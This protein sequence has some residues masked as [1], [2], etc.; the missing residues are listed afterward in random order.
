MI[1][2]LSE[3]VS[4]SSSQPHSLSSDTVLNWKPLASRRGFGSASLTKFIPFL[5]SEMFKMEI[6]VS[7]MAVCI[8]LYS[9]LLVFITITL[10]N[11]CSYLLFYSLIYS[12]NNG[13]YCATLSGD[14][15]LNMTWYWSHGSQ[16]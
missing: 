15:I 5:E 14:G 9:F 4:F 3:T 7:R 12:V 6:I 16:I 1:Q 2:S 11:I 13:I 8:K 10:F